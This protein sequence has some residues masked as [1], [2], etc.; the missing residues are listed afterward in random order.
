M[1]GEQGFY[2]LNTL[3][4]T[5]EEQQVL[6]GRLYELLIKQVNKYNGLDSTS[7]AIEKVQDILESLCYTLEVVV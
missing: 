7:M 2:V 1:M 4:L 3:V 6:L 5:E